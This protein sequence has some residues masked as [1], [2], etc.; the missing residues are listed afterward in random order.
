MPD[1]R[2]G[3]VLADEMGTGKT[4]SMLA[5]VTR[6]LADAKAWVRKKRMAEQISSDVEHYSAATLVVVPS[7]CE[8]KSCVKS[9]GK[10]GVCTDG[11]IQCS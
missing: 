5:L 4:L 9:E 7:A 8:S 10:R 6:T 2:G 11:G 3:G 1:E